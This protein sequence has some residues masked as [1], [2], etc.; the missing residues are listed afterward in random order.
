MARDHW[1]EYLRCPYCRK[2]G[3]ALV[4]AADEYSWDVRVDSAP[5]GFKVIRSGDVIN[6]YCAFC[7]RPAE[8]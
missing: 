1:V 3:V 7:D 2:A 6:F 8:P 4:S 5:E